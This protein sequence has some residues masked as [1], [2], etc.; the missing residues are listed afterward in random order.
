MYVTVTYFSEADVQ[1]VEERTNQ[2][3]SSIEKWNKV[4]Q[5]TPKLNKFILDFIEYL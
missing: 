1:E 2:V 5:V 3:I 4:E